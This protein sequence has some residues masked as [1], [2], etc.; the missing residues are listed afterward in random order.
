MTNTPAPSTVVVGV[1]ETG[2][3]RGAIRLAAREARYRG[4]GLLAIKAYHADGALGAPAGRPLAVMHSK[5]NAELI[6]L[7]SPDRH[8]AAPGTVSQYVLRRTP[9]PVLLVPESAGEAA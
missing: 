8:A 6:V 2:K 1:R 7:A 3:S 9:C 5:V 4:A